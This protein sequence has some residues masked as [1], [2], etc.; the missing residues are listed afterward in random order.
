MVTGNSVE[1]CWCTKE[2]FPNE[3]LELAAP[4][5]LNKSCICKAC[6]EKFKAKL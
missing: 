4:D 5:Q 3:I 1:A 2:K 6:L